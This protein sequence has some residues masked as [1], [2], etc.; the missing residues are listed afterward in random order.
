[1]E[2]HIYELIGEDRDTV[3][4]QPPCSP[5]MGYDVMLPAHE[6]LRLECNGRLEEPVQVVLPDV[7]WVKNVRST[8]ACH[9]TWIS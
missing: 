3:K 6:L 9:A 4:Q 5:V 7:I 8:V 2:I 1:M